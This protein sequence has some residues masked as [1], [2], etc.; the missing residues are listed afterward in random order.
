[1]NLERIRSAV[2]EIF[3]TQTKKSQT[4][5]KTAK[6]RTLRSSLRAVNTRRF[7][8]CK[9]KYSGAVRSYQAQLIDQLSVVVITT[10]V[11]ATHQPTVVMESGLVN[12]RL[13]STQLGATAAV[14]RIKHTVIQ[15]R[16]LQH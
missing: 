15:T 2:P 8:L 10:T 6:N 3:H 4:A 7:V 5:P 14:Q 13:K 9:L 1:M 11:Q 12:R 16:R